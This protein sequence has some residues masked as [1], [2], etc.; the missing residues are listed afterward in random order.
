MLKSGAHQSGGDYRANLLPSA[1]ALEY[2][3]MRP[4]EFKGGCGGKDL[5]G[6]GST[7]DACFTAHAVSAARPAGEAAMA[8]R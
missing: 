6:A 8:V 3:L 4:P 2:F 1:P 5:G 7:A